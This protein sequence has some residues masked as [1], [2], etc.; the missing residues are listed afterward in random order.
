MSRERME[1]IL[2]VALDFIDLG[3]AITLAGEA[4]SGGCDW[5]EAGTPLIKSEG[6]NCIRELRARFPKTKIVADMKIMDTGRLEV[7][8]A[9]KAGADVVAVLGC[10]HDET[11]K[12]CVDAGRNYGSQVIVDLLEVK[13]PVNRAKRVESLGADFVG[14]HIPIDEQMKGDISFE[15]VRK[16]KGEVGIPV[17]VAGGINSE[18]AIEAVE[19]GA[20]IIIVG[21]AI[22]KSMDARKA[23][24]DIKRAIR[25]KVAIETRLYKR[26]TEKD[27]RQVLS[28]VSTANISDALHRAMPLY[29]LTP[30]LGKCKMVGPAVTVRTYPGDWAKPVQAIDQA[31]EGDVIVID[32]GGVPPAV[33]GEL[34]SYS[35][36]GKKLG[37]VVIDGAIRDVD[38]IREIRF[39]AFARIVTPQAGEPKGF[40]EIGIPITICGIKIFPGDW[41]VGDADGVIVIPHKDIVEIT[42]R[43][44]DVL[45]RENRIRE[46]I[47]RGD[48]L[49]NL[50]ELLKWEKR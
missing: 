25:D 5:L 26:V 15:N 11:I 28:G 42:N 47:R 13:D 49:G 23:A 44:M 30:M 14:L 20:S 16:V 12:E 40:G 31:G 10:A 4:L 21:G 17:A 9:A 46:E 41:I 39:P 32:A 8:I 45:E 3:R 34:A 50:A 19:A 6:L 38:E 22:T 7:E 24:E 48:T 43:A 36:K 33:W 2:Q 29:G 1:T 35:A 37:G 18:N 27:A